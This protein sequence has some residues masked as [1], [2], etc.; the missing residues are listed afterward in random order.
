MISPFEDVDLITDLFM[1]NVRVSLHSGEARCI[2]GD[3]DV[4]ECSACRNI[5]AKRLKAIECTRLE[6]A[7]VRQ[8][9]QSGHLRSHLAPTPRKESHRGIQSRAIDPC[10]SASNDG[11]PARS[12]CPHKNRSETE[13]LQTATNASTHP[14]PDRDRQ[15]ET[16]THTSLNANQHK[17]PCVD[18][19]GR[20]LS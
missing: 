12:E 13:T 16:I 8:L 1:D 7:R 2:H 3:K 5:V 4:T 10:V 19:S 15:T 14:Q 11:S 17:C 9:I 18:N 6:R 20:P